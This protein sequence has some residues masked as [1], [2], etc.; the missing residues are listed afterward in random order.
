MQQTIYKNF[1]NYYQLYSKGMKLEKELV[2]TI[3]EV[4]EYLVKNGVVAEHKGLTEYE[5]KAIR[6][7]KENELIK[8]SRNSKF[9]YHSTP[10]IS[11]I[12]ELGIEKYLSKKDS[13]DNFELEIQRLTIENLQLK[14][15]QL[16]RTVLYSIIGFI[17]GAIV[18]NLKNIL[19]L[20]KILNP[21]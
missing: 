17:M 19:I 8:P 6:F 15:K 16:K 20:L 9:Q 11:K 4:A 5:S 18:T 14:N 7:L 21:E 13:E 2:I 12:K 10:E 3:N 1:G